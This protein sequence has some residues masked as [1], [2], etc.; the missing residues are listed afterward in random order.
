VLIY[1][2]AVPLFSEKK[3]VVVCGLFT[4]TNISLSPG[5]KWGFL[6]MLIYYYLL[7]SISWAARKSLNVRDNALNVTYQVNLRHPLWQPQT[8]LNIAVGPSETFM[9]HHYTTW[10][11]LSQDDNLYL[12]INLNIPHN[13]P[14]WA[15]NV[16]ACCEAWKVGVSDTWRHV[17]CIHT[18]GVIMTNKRSTINACFATILGPVD[19]ATGW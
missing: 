2:V 7:A 8:S 13:F 5:N 9:N 1:L 14:L 6:K 16:W 11:H 10:G 19:C 17:V 4:C 12:K 18:V 3:R 15:L